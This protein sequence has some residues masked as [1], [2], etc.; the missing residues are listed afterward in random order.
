MYALLYGK[1]FK[2]IGIVDKGKVSVK[3]HLC[4]RKCSAI[5]ETYQTMT[6]FLTHFM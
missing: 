4:A 3:C 1:C 5:G 2:I 6:N